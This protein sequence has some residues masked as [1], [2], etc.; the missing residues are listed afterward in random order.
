[1][2][3][4][5]KYDR[6]GHGSPSGYDALLA[7]NHCYGSRNSLQQRGHRT[8]LPSQPY[9]SMYLDLQ[10]R[11]VKRMYGQVDKIYYLYSTGMRIWA[12]HNAR[13]YPIETEWVGSSL[14][15]ISIAYYMQNGGGWVQIAC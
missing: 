11:K 12:Y 5:S 6:H 2:G 14:L 13:Y 8:F 15:Y 3:D 10:L 9:F 1:M 7:L 4:L